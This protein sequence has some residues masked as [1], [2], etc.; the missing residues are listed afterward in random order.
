LKAFQKAS[1]N[2][3]KKLTL[4]ISKS[5]TVPPRLAQQH[6]SW[7]S[8]SEKVL[9]LDCNLPRIEHGFA[10]AFVDGLL[11][12]ALRHGH[13]LLLDEINLAYKGCP[14]VSALAISV[15]SSYKRV[16]DQSTT[17]Y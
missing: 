6:E 5:D 9:R 13:W 17:M 12:D 1:E 3:L 11:V 4:A 15:V 10:F 16:V 2:A 8:F 14:S 7:S